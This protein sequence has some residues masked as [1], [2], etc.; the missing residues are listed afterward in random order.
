VFLF[1][2]WSATAILQTRPFVVKNNGIFAEILREQ[3]FSSP[4]Q[5][6][7]SILLKKF[8][9]IRRALVLD[10]WRGG[11]GK[12]E[13][14]EKIMAKGKAVSKK[15]SKRREQNEV[16]NV[17]ERD[18]RIEFNGPC[19]LKLTGPSTLPHNAIEV[20]AL[21]LERLNII[22]G[23]VV[24]LRGKRRST[25]VTVPT[26]TQANLCRLLLPTRNHSLHVEHHSSGC[27]GQDNE[28]R[29]PLH[30]RRFRFR[31]SSWCL[32]HAQPTSRARGRGANRYGDFS[33][34]T[35]TILF[36][37][38]LLTWPLGLNLRFFERVHVTQ[39]GTDFLLWQC[40]AR[41]FRLRTHSR[42]GRG[43]GKSHC[44]RT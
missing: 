23:S 43:R 17:V 27:G 31:G 1:S 34:F 12:D 6:T 35:T 20:P 21:E 15:K 30:E 25:T 37:I 26:F 32:N 42:R 14:V 7:S 24:R 44:V 2:C 28:G 40:Q 9:S 29:P 3:E 8:S 39:K 4:L 16:K 18:I 41:C 19:L 5:G 10:R 36:D 11:G 13:H 38:H 33:N 22:E